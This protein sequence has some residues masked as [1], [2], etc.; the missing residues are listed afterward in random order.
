VWYEKAESG[1][2]HLMFAE[3]IKAEKNVY[4]AVVFKNGERRAEERFA[5][6]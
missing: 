3:H 4:T 2:R 6:L 1:E 5:N